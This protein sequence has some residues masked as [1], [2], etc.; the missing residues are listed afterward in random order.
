MEIIFSLPIFFIHIA[1][2]TISLTSNCGDLKFM[3]I[4]CATK[5]RLKK[6]KN[7]NASHYYIFGK[8]RN[9]N[10]GHHCRIPC[11]NKYS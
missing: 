4:C 5:N 8:V 9:R 7:K 2:K 1:A 3:F 6:K 10:I 11:A